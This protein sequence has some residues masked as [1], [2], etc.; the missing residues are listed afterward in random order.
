MPGGHG[1]GGEPV[2]DVIDAFGT[3]FSA[4]NPVHLKRQFRQACNVADIYEYLGLVEAGEPLTIALKNGESLTLEPM[5]ME[6]MGELGAARLSDRV[7]GTPETAAQDVCYFSK[8]L[9]EEVY[10][11]QY[12]VC[13]E[14]EDL[15]M[16]EFAAQVAKDLEEGAIG[17]CC[18]TSDTTA[19]GPTA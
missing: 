5:G 1:A 10:Y 13:R 16:E 7:E 2:G 6:E 14:D 15:P 17:G 4:D 8:P 3:L 12:N 18:W 9:S 11:I 19:A